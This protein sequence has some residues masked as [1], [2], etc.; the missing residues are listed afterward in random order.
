MIW[1]CCVTNCC[2]KEKKEQNE[3]KKD[4]N[5]SK[6]C[7]KEKVESHSEVHNISEKNKLMIMNKKRIISGVADVSDAGRCPICKRKFK[8][9]ESAVEY[10]CVDE[11]FYH[12]DCPLDYCEY[13][14]SKCLV[15]DLKIIRIIR[16]KEHVN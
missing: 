9:K 7:D 10:N 4:E 16:I 5:K 15:C 8:L 13:D 1:T 3:N 14:I 12:A 11:Y 2:R 6:K